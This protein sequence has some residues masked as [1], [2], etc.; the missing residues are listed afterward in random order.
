MSI[1]V[2]IGAPQSSSFVRDR[3]VIAPCLSIFGANEKRRP[4]A[5]FF[6][7]PYIQNIRLGTFTT[8]S[9]GKL[10]FFWNELI[11]GDCS[12]QRA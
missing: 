3:V 9:S 5:A 2:G 8:P 11:W 4:L 12:S 10:Y 1:A 7:D 6:F